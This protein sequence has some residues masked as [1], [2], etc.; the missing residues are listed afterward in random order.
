MKRVSDKRLASGVRLGSNSTI[1]RKPKKKRSKVKALIA[2]LPDRGV[3][4]R[5]REAE[6]FAQQFG[7]VGRVEWVKSL[8]SVFSG[9]GPCVNMHTRGDGTSRKADYIWIVPATD[10][11]HQ[12]SHRGQKTFAR[13]YGIDL[14]LAATQIEALWSGTMKCPRCG[15]SVMPT[16][17]AR[18]EFFCGDFLDCGWGI[19]WSQ[20][21]REFPA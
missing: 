6:R 20:I 19:K 13:K 1:S 21:G 18:G 15:H 4:K 12:E 7:S 16:P 9:R 8:P 5:D 3:V 10:G 11:E 17:T 14:E 2:K